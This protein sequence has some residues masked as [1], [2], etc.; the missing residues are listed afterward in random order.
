MYL[1]KKQKDYFCPLIKCS[2]NAG[3][4][5]IS[6]VDFQNSPGEHAPGPS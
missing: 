3:Y 2:A 4:A 6:V 1:L 5:A